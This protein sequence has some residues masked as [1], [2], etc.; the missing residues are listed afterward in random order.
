MSDYR[1][2]RLLGGYC[3][4]WADPTVPSGRRRYRLKATTV[5]AAHAEARALF[6]DLT[7]PTSLAT[8]A[9]VWEA[10]RKDKEPRAIATTMKH[11]GKAVLAHFGALDPVRITAEDC[12]AYTARRRAQGRSDGATH[13]ELGHLRMALSWAAKPGRRLIPEAVEIE[14]PQKPDP[15]DRWLTR[16]EVD[17]LLAAATAPHI[18]LAIVLM[19]ST[20][21]RVGAILELTWDRCDFAEGTINLRLH[22]DQPRKGRAIAPMN[23]TARA[24]LLAAR[25]G[26]LSDHVIEWGG[27]PVR[28]ILRGVKAAA[29][30]AGMP[31]VSPHCLRHTA[32][33]WML[34]A[35][36][37]IGQV[38]R[39]LGHSNTATTERVYAKYT[40]DSLRDAAEVLE[41]GGL[42]VVK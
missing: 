9:E 2:G 5:E 18:R 35:G 30:R 14:R 4:T 29:R 7:G 10:Y 26:A 24:A 34:S 6:V 25:E 27:E 15:K 20:A 39:L 3:I 28:C 17:K 22:A 19:L 13:T 41:I 31:E 32:A 11:T 36:H 8:V 16:P 12:R 40:I 1:V 42:T 37:P 38:S 21:G 33:V 23:R